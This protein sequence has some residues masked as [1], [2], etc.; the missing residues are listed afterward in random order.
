[1]DG[2]ALFDYDG[3]LRNL[4]LRLVPSAES[5]RSVAPTGGTRHTAGR[6]YSA[7]EPDSVVVAVSESGPVTVFRRGEVIGRSDSVTACDPSAVTDPA[8]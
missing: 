3:T 5:E 2:A 1:V 8:P 6:R 7:D 4:G